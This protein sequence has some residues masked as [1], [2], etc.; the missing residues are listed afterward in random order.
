M[1]SSL[2]LDMVSCVL[3]YISLL[4]VVSFDLVVFNG[5]FSTLACND[6]ILS[7][8]NFSSCTLVCETTIWSY[9]VFNLCFL[10][11]DVVKIPFPGQNAH[12]TANTTQCI[13]FCAHIL[14]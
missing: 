14:F 12:V 10:L 7:V 1:I 4:L 13:S 3:I 6:I 9:L 11:I 2:Y 8:R 5:F